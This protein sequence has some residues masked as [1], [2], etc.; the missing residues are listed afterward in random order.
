MVPVFFALAVPS[1]TITPSALVTDEDKP[2]DV[3]LQADVAGARFKITKPAKRGTATLNEKTGALNYVAWPEFHGADRIRV[4]VSADGKVVGVDLPIVVNAVNDLPVAE[5][6][7]LVTREE[8]STTGALKV[9]DVDRDKLSFAIGAQPAHGTASVDAKGKVT[10]TPAHDACGKDRFVVVVDDGAAKIEVAIDVDV[11]AMNDAP[12]IA[13]ANI[14]GSEDAPA[15][16]TLAATDID[17]DALSF[18]VKKAPKQGTAT[19]DAKSGVLTFTPAPNWNGD[20]VVGVVVTDG[21]AKTGVDVPIHV[22]AVNDP[23][24]VQ[25]LRLTTNEDATASAVVDAREV[26]GDKLSFSLATPPSSGTASVDAQ[27]KVTFTP[28]PN[29][30]GTERFVVV[31]DDG[32]AKVEI[33]VSV[34]VAAVNDTPTVAA[35]RV[36]GTE[37]TAA[38]VQLV[39]AD[40]DGD[41]LTWELKKAPKRGT[42]TVDASSGL[43]RYTPEPDWNGAVSATVRVTDGKGGVDVDVP[44]TIA[45]VNDAPVVQ[46]LKLATPE[47]AAT[48]APIDVR[49]VDRDKLSFS[50]TTPA[51]LGTASVDAKGRVTYKP[52][53]DKNGNDRFVVAVSDG[54]ATVELPIDVTVDAVNDAPVSTSSPLSFAEDTE[55]TA[56]LTATDVDGDRLRFRATTAPNGGGRFS[57]SSTGE[58]RWAPPANYNGRDKIQFELDDG[59]V[60]TAVTLSV[61][62]TPVNDAPTLKTRNAV[63][64]EDTVTATDALA[65]D[66]DGDKL[67][68]RIEKQGEK[69]T[70]TVDSKGVVKV[71]PIHDAWGKDTIVVAVDDGTT[72]TTN[73][74]VVTIEAQPDPPLVRDDSLATDEDIPA[75]AT[76]PATDPDGDPLTFKLTST[77]TLG[78]ATLLDARTGRVAYKP[79]K[80]VFGDDVVGFEV[81]D[82][83]DDRRHR[84]AG[85]LVVSIKPVDD[86]PVAGD[87]SAE[88]NEDTPAHGTVTMTD[89]DGDALALTIVK[90]PD[91]G[92]ARVDDAAHGTFV[93]EPTRDFNGETSFVVAATET[94]SGRLVSAPATVRVKVKPVNDAPATRGLALRANE[95]TPVNGAVAASDIDRDTL[96][97]IVA[98][99]PGS[100]VVTL[101]AQSGRLSYTPRK[102]THGADFFV[103]TVD[104]GAGGSADAR[105]DVSV[106]PVDDAPVAIP[107]ELMSP[108]N[109]R[110]TG[111]LLGRDPEGDA[112]TFRIVEPPA[113]GKLKL[114]DEKTGDYAFSIE[115]GA[116]GTTAPF[117]F[118]VEAGGKKSEP[119]TV[120]IRIE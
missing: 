3:T 90:Q 104:D 88:T 63:T 118:V 75:E 101:D 4:E 10:F 32:S 11:T 60:R 106:V 8:A 54:T 29:A 103:V 18:E 40:I 38:S 78:T 36:D 12:T 41:K 30:F 71:T 92:V 102:N 64:N 55:L 20:V 16:V 13:A 89:V 99:Q 66:I 87:A 79:N 65:N 96:R 107:G 82:G 44:I 83:V 76:L 57:L 31:A 39:G 35:A 117:R 98:K 62:V 7:K 23:P 34:D 109:G 113:V 56:A 115:G 25:P 111:K 84:V 17:G 46:P 1:L 53:R 97:F 86:A 69:A 19:I 50:V 81:N 42:A 70:A 116:K 21:K 114:L 45:A 9:S 80:D 91:N 93:V 15:S 68:L 110:A 47:D 74:F 22:A 77:G 72:T 6:L 94:A 112:L 33:P 5:A 27:G 108:R 43:L 119:V 51:T 61:T 28:A 120:V 73:S 49:D 48:S 67:T 2:L 59:T 100:G 52:E 14:D 37:D 24:L 105:V 26:D 95:D 58:L 85:R